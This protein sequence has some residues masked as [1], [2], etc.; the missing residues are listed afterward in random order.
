M[1]KNTFWQRFRYKIPNLFF[2]PHSLQEYEQIIS[3]AKEQGYKFYTLQNFRTAELS[4]KESFIILR[5]DIDTDPVAALRFAEIELRYAV[6]ASYFFRRIT[7][8]AGI[9]NTLHRQGHEIGYHFE[10]LSDYAKKHHIKRKEEILKQ[11]PSIRESFAANL[12]A[13]RT[14]VDFPIVSAAAHGD[15]TYKTLNEGNKIFLKDA[16]LRAST[17]IVYEAYDEPLVS[18]YRNHISDKPAPQGFYPV[19]PQEL[20]QQKESFLFLSHP[21]WWIPNPLVSTISDG[22]GIVQKLLW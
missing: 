10:E 22:R 6:K 3:D 8:H 15:F 14:T 4:D 5:H 18:K 13:L 17:G 19:S 9:M 21:R 12:S 16:K 2:A 1:F 20:I 11:L 7:W